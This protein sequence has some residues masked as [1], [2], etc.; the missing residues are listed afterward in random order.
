MPYPTLQEFI[1][2]L[3][4]LGE[5]RRISHPADPY[6]E[7]TEIADRVMK[8]GGPALL[9]ERPRGHEVPLLINAFGSRRRMSAAL[10]VE[11]LEE[12]AAEIEEMTRLELP[13]GWGDRMR[14]LPR[15]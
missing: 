3:D 8:S 9:F 2:D 13:A 12:I 4:G 11:D 7:I 6:L 5:L 15:L 1:A 14:L 10:G